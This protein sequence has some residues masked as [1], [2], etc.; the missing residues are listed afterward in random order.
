L[1]QHAWFEGRG[2][3]NAEFLGIIDEH[4]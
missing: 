1:I 3:R 2:Y 4:D